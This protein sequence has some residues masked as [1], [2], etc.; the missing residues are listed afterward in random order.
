MND[1]A[2][3]AIETGLAALTRGDLDALE[4]VW[5]S[6][7]TLKA[8]EPGPWDCASRQEVMALLHLRESQRPPGQPRAVKVTRHDD[9][10]FLVSGVG[11]A[12]GT[13]TVVTVANGRVIALQQ[14]TAAPGD[15]GGCCTW[16]PTGRDIPRAARRWCTC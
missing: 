10:T 2:S 11:G 5:D 9:A 8:V 14:V 6:H 13:A 1:S 16:W 7:V 15:T 12:E 4:R 3:A